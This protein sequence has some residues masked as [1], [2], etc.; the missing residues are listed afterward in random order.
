M[1]HDA[2]DAIEK[3]QKRRQERAIPIRTAVTIVTIIVK[4]ETKL[5]NIRDNYNAMVKINNADKKTLAGGVLPV[6]QGADNGGGSRTSPASAKVKKERK[7]L[8]YSYA[9]NI[10]NDTNL[11]PP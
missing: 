4:G 1:W 5:V 10:A 9:I 8:L 2:V 3:I 7:F 6:A 11:Q